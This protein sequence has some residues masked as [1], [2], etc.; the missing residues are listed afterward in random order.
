MGSR[1]KPKETKMSNALN[2]P[3]APVVG[4]QG[5]KSQ[6]G[7]H[8]LAYKNQPAF[9]PTATLSIVAGTN[10]PWRPNTPGFDFYS[11]VLAK[12]PKTVAEA[13][14]MGAK[15]GLKAGQ[16]QA[17]LRWLFTWGGA[18]LSVDGKLYSASQA[19]VSTV[20]KGKKAKV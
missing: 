2:T 13:I 12:S 5:K 16:V 10:N 17:H 11:T 4:Q 18:Y 3:V 20:A 7:G 6:H 19:P 1:H 8:Y 15:A 9:A 14:A